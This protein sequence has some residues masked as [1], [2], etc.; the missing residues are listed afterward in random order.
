MSAPAEIQTVSHRASSASHHPRTE[1]PRS[2]ARSRTEVKR[3]SPSI[4]ISSLG[5]TEVPGLVLS[6]SGGAAAS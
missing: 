4:V 5:E 1:V 2:L 3:L 6:D